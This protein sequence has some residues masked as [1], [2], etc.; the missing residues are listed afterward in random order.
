LES[1]VLSL[2]LEFVESLDLEQ[3][4]VGRVVV[5]VIVI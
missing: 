3:V 1:L 5:L 2:L 4:L